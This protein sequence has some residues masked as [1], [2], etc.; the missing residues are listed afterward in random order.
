[1]WPFWVCCPSTMRQVHI[2]PIKCT[3]VNLC[4][5]WSL[6][7]LLL[8]FGFLVNASVSTNVFNY[9]SCIGFV[10]EIIINAFGICNTLDALITINASTVTSM[11]DILVLVLIEAN[12]TWLQSYLKYGSLR[13]QYVEHGARIGTCIVS[14][15]AVS[16]LFIYLSVFLIF[17]Y[18]DSRKRLNEWQLDY[19]QPQL[20]WT[21]HLEANE[22][23]YRELNL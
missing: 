16:T 12:R 4:C 19:F 18:L 22:K 7:P 8:A 13:A 21:V 14:P 20:E 11:F 9:R 15:C 3:H 5:Q 6:V 17:V 1:M 23:E 2:A 10:K